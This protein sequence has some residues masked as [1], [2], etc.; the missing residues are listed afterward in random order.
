MI[1]EMAFGTVPF[2]LFNLLY[3]DFAALV[4]KANLN[5]DECYFFFLSF[6]LKAV[7]FYGFIESGYSQIFA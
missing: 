6:F 2:N 4:R 1:E 3:I 5:G 7:I